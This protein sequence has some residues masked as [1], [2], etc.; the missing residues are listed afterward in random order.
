MTPELARSSD[1]PSPIARA[2]LDGNAAAGEFA[3]IF[4]FD[5]TTAIVR[6]GGCAAAEPFGRLHAYLG[7]PGTV[8]RCPQCEAMVA[9]VACT[10]RGIWLDLS[11]SSSWL[12]PEAPIP[13]SPASA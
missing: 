6:C 2:A 7:G 8:L 4:A 1:G 12:L 10:A 5:P 3:A 9:R 13:D 11:G